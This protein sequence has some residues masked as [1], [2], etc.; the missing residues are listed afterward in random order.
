MRSWQYSQALAFLLMPIVGDK[1]AELTADFLGKPP[2]NPP[3]VSHCLSSLWVQM[4]LGLI[5][6]YCCTSKLW[7]HR[8]FP[9]LV[10]S[11]C[12][13]I[14]IRTRIDEEP[15]SGASASTW[16]RSETDATTFLYDRTARITE[17][18]T[19]IYKANT[20]CNNK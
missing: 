20:I 9:F 14:L 1:R 2:M 16:H 6:S 18:K 13:Q 10:H 7:F 12:G 15:L 19:V 17:A 4:V 8:Y 5:T 3:L 11:T